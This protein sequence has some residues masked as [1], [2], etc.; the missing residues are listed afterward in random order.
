MYYLIIKLEERFFTKTDTSRDYK[1]I[2]KEKD[3]LIGACKL[4]RGLTQN[5]P[6][7]VF[8]SFELNS[9]S[10]KMKHNSL[11][12]SNKIQ[13]KHVSSCSLKQSG[14]V[15]SEEQQYRFWKRDISKLV[16]V[17]VR[18]TK[19]K[20][21]AD[22][23]STEV[24]TQETEAAWLTGPRSYIVKD[25][26]NCWVCTPSPPSRGPHPWLREVTQIEG[27]GGNTP[28]Y[29]RTHTDAERFCW[30]AQHPRD[31]ISKLIPV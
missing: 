29:C 19:P 8:R 21:T 22:N 12:I 11:R 3:K 31:R 27:R 17:Y 28:V 23:K 5:G 4:H 6:P 7:S 24:V 26:F 25:L 13:K 9:P 15:Q 10:N 1:K 18:I 14:A 2:K 16:S 20:S 30:A